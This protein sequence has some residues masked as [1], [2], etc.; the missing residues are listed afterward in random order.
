MLAGRG[1]CGVNA[2]GGMALERVGRETV[3]MVWAG[4][5]RYRARML[6]CERTTRIS[7][8]KFMAPGTW[9]PGMAL[10]QRVTQWTGVADSS[11]SSRMVMSDFS[12]MRNKIVAP[13]D[14]L[15]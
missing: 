3:S 14:S 2:R 8:Q 10:Q 4:S 15:P 12:C 7:W 11:F 9:V 13:T 6:Y 5:L 1:Q